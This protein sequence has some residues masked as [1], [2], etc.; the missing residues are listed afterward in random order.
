MI[1]LVVWHLCR[2]YSSFC[3]A[4]LCWAAHDIASSFWA[5]TELVIRVP[6]ELRIAHLR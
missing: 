6:A 3:V 5:F 4:Q 1:L 2:F